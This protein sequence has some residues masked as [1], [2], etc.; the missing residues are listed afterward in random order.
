VSN[1]DDDTDPS[2]PSARRSSRPAP[3]GLE[4]TDPGVGEPVT[5][6]VAVPKRPL[7]IVVPGPGLSTMTPTPAPVTTQ[8]GVVRPKDSVEILLDGM[9]D[10]RLER[11]RTT[12]QSDGQAS[13]A[14][15]SEHKPRA[16]EKAIDVTVPKVLLDR[17]L[18]PTAVSPRKS[19][20]PA[21]PYSAEATVMIPPPRLG[22]RLMLAVAGGLL[23]AAVVFM[24]LRATATREGAPAPQA[25][26]PTVTAVGNPSPGAS[27]P[28]TPTMTAAAA[29]A[30]P[31]AF[32]PPTLPPPPAAAEA[33]ATA[34]AASTS[35]A[36][37]HLAA[38]PA[39]S[40][41]KRHTKAAPAPTASGDIGE[42]RTNF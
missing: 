19:P 12:P 4:G 21:R 39:S 14:Y 42:F 36:G 7:G 31:V 27:P 41:L 6:P 8:R 5:E 10:Q 32:E 17:P 29:N 3:P 13:A 16:S 2:T 25:A 33:S 34:P 18:T 28:P 1:N 20:T 24:L 22:V 35:V 15:H 40:T 9:T 37:S 30:I 23:V 11:T 38:A 26:D